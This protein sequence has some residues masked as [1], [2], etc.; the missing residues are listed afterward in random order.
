[1]SRYYIRFK[2]I[3]GKSLRYKLVPVAEGSFIS[4]TTYCRTNIDE[5]CDNRM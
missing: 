3:E 1:M 2:N 5:Q 4:L